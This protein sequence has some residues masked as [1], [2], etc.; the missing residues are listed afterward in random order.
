[1]KE[2]RLNLY[3]ERKVRRKMPSIGIIGGTDGPV[4]I[5][6][7][8]GD[9]GLFHNYFQNMKVDLPS[10]SAGELLKEIFLSPFGAAF[11]GMMI[12]AYL[13][14]NI[15]PS[16]LLAKARGI[17]I[18]KEGSGNAGTTNALRVMG[19]KAGAITLI[20][21][22]LKG[23]AAVL[24][25][26]L[27]CGHLCAM[28]C[29]LAAMLG[30][31]WPVFYRF[32]GGKGV[33]TAFGALL[34]LNPLLALSA[35]AIVV[36]VVLITKRMS[37]GSIVVAVLFPVLSRFLEPDFVLLGSVLAILIIVKHRSNLVRLFKGEEPKMSIF[38]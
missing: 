32:K 26:N 6:L 37:V 36:V 27:V 13:L 8:G 2:H 12:L 17:D 16:T 9:L 24:I 1:M 11:L 7:A 23:A 15:S 14:G 3:S 38:K 29:V 5:F 31:I 4:Q 18:K 21:D 30:H 28:F 33:A 25:G 35:L 10:V 34:G 22:V 20:V 19:K